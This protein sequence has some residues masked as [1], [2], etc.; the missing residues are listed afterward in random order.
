[1]NYKATKLLIEKR[2]NILFLIYWFFLLVDEFKVAISLIFILFIYNSKSILNFLKKHPHILLL[3]IISFI[4]YFNGLI[5]ESKLL[6]I[7]FFSFIA[8]LLFHAIYNIKPIR[9][10]S[11][12][13]G[14]GCIVL[15]SL[16]Y[17]QIF[18]RLIE[19]SKDYIVI[20]NYFEIIVFL[21]CINMYLFKINDKEKLFFNFLVDSKALIVG[22][23]LSFFRLRIF[24]FITILSL[25]FAFYL[26]PYGTLTTR[27]NLFDIFLSYFN[28]HQFIFGFKESVNNLV[29]NES[30]I[31]SFH[32]IFIDMIWYGGLLG[33]IFIPIIIKNTYKAFK[34]EKTVYLKKIL[35]WFF[36]CL[37]F[38]FPPFN[39]ET[40]F[41]FYFYAIIVLKVAQDE[42]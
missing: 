15:L 12:V 6:I 23:L 36:I 40:K 5:V 10:I 32:N 20:K 18:F 7:Y 27:L 28:F 37:L 35:F 29:W 4:S 38:C 13:Y 34:N 19:D 22:T 3:P 11:F 25:I 17:D 33:V 39:G 1:M 41:L 8:C 26:N 24:I 42:N 21:N 2:I 16:T 31:F 30:G 14:G 9:I